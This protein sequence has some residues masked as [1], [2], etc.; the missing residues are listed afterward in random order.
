M[1]DDES[2][3]TVQRF[4]DRAADYVRYRP[5][6][7]AETIDT[8]LAGLRP[9]AELLAADI[10]AGTGISA[11]LVADRGVR[12]I[13]VEPGGNMRASADPHA[14]VSW[15]AG[16]AEATGLRS[17]A[18]DLVVC[19]QAFHWFRH[20]AA[21]PEFARILRPRGRL[22]IVWNRRSR[23]DPFTAGYREA[24]LSVGGEI[25]AER[26]PFDPGVLAAS[27]LF[28]APDRTSVPNV[29]R[30]DLDG[31]IGRA[32]S[33]SYV[34]KSGPA[35]ARLLDLL[36]GL[37]ARYADATGQATL[38]YETELFRSTRVDR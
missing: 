37:H 29:Q 13:A 3:D 33:A 38:V 32:H 9:A 22:A 12:V 30:F 18:V 2:R 26:M 19:A 23:E 20:E 14:R 36:R 6:Y 17:A 8:I 10:G 21:L 25:T 7:P 11:R 4:S 5:G 24:I 27:G 1:H 28:T 35:A 16:T 31:L 34:P 15:I